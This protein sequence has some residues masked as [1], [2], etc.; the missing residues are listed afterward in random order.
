ML[1]LGRGRTAAG[2]SPQVLGCA[3][4]P[5]SPPGLQ[6]TPSDEEAGDRALAP[7]SQRTRSPEASLGTV[8]FRAATVSLTRR[9]APGVGCGHLAHIWGEFY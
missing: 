7:G 2:L 6:G 4:G 1:G 8:A 3:D 5:G 9:S